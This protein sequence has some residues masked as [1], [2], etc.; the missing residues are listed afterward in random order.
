MTIFFD[1]IF[2]KCLNE[3]FWQ[4]FWH[5]SFTNFFDQSLLTNI[6]DQ[7]FCQFFD[8]FF[9]RIFWWIIFD[10]FYDKLFFDQFFFCKYV[11]KNGSNKICSNQIRIRQELP[12]HL[13]CGCHSSSQSAPLF[14]FWKPGSVCDPGKKWAPCSLKKA[15]CKKPR[16]LLFKKRR[17]SLVSS[18]FD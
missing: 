4:N 1:K 6:F 16:S 8:Q 17:G 13:W 2:G 10:K 3:Y 9:Q 12:V 5:N 11:L 14:L 18:L 15:G 7:F